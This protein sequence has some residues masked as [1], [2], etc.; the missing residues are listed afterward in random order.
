MTSRSISAAEAAKRLLTLQSAATSFRGFVTAVRP[1]FKLAYFQEALIEALD[2]LERRTLSKRNLLITMPPR[3]G[4]SWLA[5]VMF[6]A[7]FILRKPDRA[8]LSVSY[9][10]ELSQNFGRQVRDLTLEPLIGH[11]FPDFQMSHT[12]SA[13]DDWRTTDEGV[14]YACGIGGGTTGRPANL[15]NIDDPIKNRTEAESAATRNKVWSFYNSSLVNRLQ[16]ELDGTPP[17]QLLTQTRWHP[18]DLAGRIMQ[19]KD[20]EDGDW[21]HIN[22]PAISRKT[23]CA[24]KPRFELPPSDPKYLPEAETNALPPDERLA[25]ETEEV[26]LWPERFPLDVL[27]KMQRRDP[28]EFAALY[29]QSPYIRGGNLIKTIWFGTYAKSEIPD[30]YQLVIMAADTAFKAN[31]QNDYSVLMTMGLTSS[32][33]IHIIDVV[34]ERLDYPSLRRRIITENAK[35]RGRGLRGIYIEDRASGQSFVQDLR[36]QSGISVIA[37]KNPGN[38][39]GIGHVERAHL[40]LP[41]IEGGRVFLPEDAPWLDAFLEEAQ[42]FGPS[43]PHDDQ[44]DAM[45]I[46]LDVLSRLGGVGD[47]SSFE[48]NIS[49][50]NSLNSLATSGALGPLSFGQGS[51]L[52][53]QN[54]PRDADVRQSNWVNFKPLGEL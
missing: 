36:L 51:S 47:G 7:Y 6:P 49:L 53:T 26:A 41:L 40:V 4:K 54:F 21:H 18:D 35:W 50:G 17:I 22:Y 52:N 34:R 1:E 38:R 32:G 9:G 12:S 24:P 48:N 45:C 39:A 5:T 44:I 20:W 42:A 31:K 2:A 10:A 37:Y 11:A 43:C 46:G 3:H 15:L 27:H 23:I 14:Y 25:S 28:R 13:I 16:P 8:I 19:T 29:Q 30:R 33:D